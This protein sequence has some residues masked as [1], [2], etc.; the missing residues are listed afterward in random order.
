MLTQTL[1]PVIKGKIHFSPLSVLHNWMGLV[2]GSSESSVSVVL[3]MV[4][5]VVIFVF[6]FVFVFVFTFLF[7]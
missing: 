4:V 2:V 7:F 6:V 5:F 3:V 1:S